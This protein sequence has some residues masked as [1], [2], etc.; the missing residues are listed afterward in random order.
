LED[1]YQTLANVLPKSSDL[2]KTTKLEY[3]R[4]AEK[5]G[6]Q[7]T[8]AS[9]EYQA[10][11][12]ADSSTQIFQGASRLDYQDKKGTTQNLAQQ[13]KLIQGRAFYNTGEFWIDS[14]LQE[15]QNCP[16]V[17]IKFAGKEYF[18]L[19]KAAPSMAELLALG[20]NVRFVFEGK[21]YEIYE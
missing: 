8:Q 1:Q 14:K 15:Q 18:E 11:S 13:I 16:K 7:S 21:I 3:D 10:L 20:K 9:Q 19:L 4:A 17:T 12:T 6:A 5:S 2:I